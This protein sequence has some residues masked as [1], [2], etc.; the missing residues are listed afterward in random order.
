MLFAPNPSNPLKRGNLWAGDKTESITGLTG[1]F[2]YQI[3]EFTD[4]NLD[5]KNN[6]LFVPVQFYPIAKKLMLNSNPLSLIDEN[7]T[8]S[9]QTNVNNAAEIA[10]FVASNMD[11]FPAITSPY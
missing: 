8:T 2:T 4:T 3:N 10:S 9:R 7:V 6:A 5:S 1:V 11:S